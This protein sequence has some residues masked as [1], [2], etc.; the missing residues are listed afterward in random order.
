MK[1]AVIGAGIAGV[2]LASQLEKSGVEV[3]VYEKSRGIGGR[4]SNRHEEWGRVELGAQ[5]FTARDS[6]FIEQVEQWQQ[7]GLVEQWHLQPHVIDQ[8][9][10]SQS[11]DQTPRFVGMPTMNAPVKQLAEPLDVFFQHRV[12]S[13]AKTG[14]QWFLSFTN[15]T[16][17]GPFDAVALCIPQAQALHLAQDLLDAAQ[18]SQLQERELRPVWAV[19]LQSDN[20]ELKTCE[21]DAAFVKNS[22]ID[23][24]CQHNKKPGREADPQSSVWTLHFSPTWTSEHLQATPEQLTEIAAQQLARLLQLSQPLS[25]SNLSTQRWLYAKGEM[26]HATD[27]GFVL[28]SNGLA[29]CGDWLQ[30]GRVE[31]AYLSGLSLANEMD[32]HWLN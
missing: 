15:Y 2:T 5:Y 24:L 21:V 16:K 11:P 26:E 9:Q 7:A 19:A 27:N 17:A 10:I 6:R 22:P 13:I 8:E 12:D 32:K 20:Q 25:I 31:G 28:L 29:F 18:L 1:V 14:E 3:S 4:M 23:W 30:A